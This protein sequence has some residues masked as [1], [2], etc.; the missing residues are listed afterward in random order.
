ME[1]EGLGEVGECGGRGYRTR[2]IGTGTRFVSLSLRYS[3]SFVLFFSFSSFFVSSSPSPVQTRT[4]IPLNVFSW[5]SPAPNNVGIAAANNTAGTLFGRSRGPLYRAAT[6]ATAVEWEVLMHT[7]RRWLCYL[8][9]GWLRPPMRQRCRLAPI[10]YLVIRCGSVPKVL[11][12]NTASRPT[13]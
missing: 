2:I 4:V 3:F 5:A 8:E 13:F 11:R 9:G 10:P 12:Q 6:G 7:E 1:G